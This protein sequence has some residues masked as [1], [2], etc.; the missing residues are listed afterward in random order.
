MVTGRGKVDHMLNAFHAKLI[1]CLQGIQTTVDLG[2]GQ[3]I[4]ETDE[5]L[6]VQAITFEA[7][8]AA[9]VGVLIVRSRH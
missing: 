9:D 2:I 7:F 4:I 6:V 1:A 8:D 3:L 5:K